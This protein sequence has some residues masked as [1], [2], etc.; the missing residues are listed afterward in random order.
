MAS[1]QKSHINIIYLLN[2]FG[3]VLYMFPIS[4]RENPKTESQYIQTNCSIFYK[5]SDSNLCLSAIDRIQCLLTNLVVL[6]IEISSRLCFYNN[7]KDFEIK[8]SSILQERIF[9]VQLNVI[10]LEPLNQSKSRVKEIILKNNN[11]IFVQLFL[12]F[13]FRLH[14]P[15]IA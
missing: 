15:S 11:F 7:V 13:K 4:F 2:H 1:T 8:Y 14:K 3:Y 5:L 9:T 6:K 10:V 12:N